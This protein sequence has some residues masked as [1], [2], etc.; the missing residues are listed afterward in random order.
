MSFVAWKD[1]VLRRLLA[2]PIYHQTECHYF[3]KSEQR[4]CRD[5]YDSS[6]E[7]FSVVR[8]LKFG[9]KWSDQG[10]TYRQVEQSHEGHI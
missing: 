10:I 9:T 2:R 6:D 3:A 7:T 8:A 1:R 4:I 5:C